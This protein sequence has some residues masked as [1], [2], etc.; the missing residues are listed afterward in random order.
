MEIKKNIKKCIII[1]LI[2]FLII[3]GMIYYYFNFYVWIHYRDNVPPPDT[4]IW[5]NGITY[6]KEINKLG[7]F[8]SGDKNRSLTEEELNELKELI[9]E[10]QSI[11]EESK[12]C[13]Y[14]EDGIT[15]ENKNYRYSDLNAEQRKIYNAIEEIVR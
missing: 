7:K 2:I 15:I 4:M 11:T 9:K 3:V 13:K 5:N 8:I 1:G 12:D 6:N 14:Y 10:F